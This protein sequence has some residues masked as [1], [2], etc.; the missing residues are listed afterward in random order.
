MCSYD[1][2]VVVVAHYIFMVG[3][4]G[5]TAWLQ[6]ILQNVMYQKKRQQQ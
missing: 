4:Y 6:I 1:A 2:V 5:T 3:R